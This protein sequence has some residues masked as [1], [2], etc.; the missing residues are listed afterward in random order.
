MSGS[1]KRDFFLLILIIITSYTFAA[2]I[3]IVVLGSST[4]AGSGPVNINNA[5]VYRY[6]TYLRSLNAGN[7]V[8]NLAKGGYVTFQALPNDYVPPTGIT[9]LP[10]TLHNITQALSL[11]PNA[12]II[13]FPSNDVSNGISIDQQIANYNIMIAKANEVNVPVWICTS[14][15]VNYG[16]SQTS[17]DKIK[18]L[19][20]RIQAEYKDMSIDFYSVLCDETG[21]ILAQYDSG[22]GLHLNDDA[23]AILYQRVKEANIFTKINYDPETG[24][25]LLQNPVYIDFGANVSPAPWNNITN[26]IAGGIGSKID[27]LSDFNGLSTGISMEVSKSFYGL[28]TFGPTITATSLNMPGTA[29]SDNFFTGGG[30]GEFLIAGLS[31]NQIYTFTFFGSRTEIGGMSRE[32]KYTV[33]GNTTSSGVLETMNNISNV[34]V[35]SGIKPA[36]N[37]SFTIEVTNGTGNLNSSKYSHISALKISAETVNGVEQQNLQNFTVWNNNGKV[38]ASFTGKGEIDI[39]TLAGKLIYSNTYYNNSLKTVEF[40]LSEKGIFIVLFKSENG[41]RARKA[42]F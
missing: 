31:P 5:W 25:Q 22:D 30:F 33:R 26:N 9:F 2:G 3:K 4:A 10:D 40:N 36:S 37:K 21:K 7:S 28:N 14:Q 23:H 13:N 32:T 34:L 35:L 41:I 24:T 29:S 18:A 11:S 17:R 12:I 6:S 19:N 42:I 1:V 39:L 16:T 15:P 8:V 38:F 20:E 27:N